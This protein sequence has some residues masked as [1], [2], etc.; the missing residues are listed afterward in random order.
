MELKKKIIR[1]VIE[2]IIVDLMIR[3]RCFTSSFI[4]R[5]VATANLKWKNHDSPLGKA[6]D[7]EDIEL[8]RKMATVMP[9]V[10]LREY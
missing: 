6:T 5:A 7:V 10:R 4:G 3:R 1:T 8:I 9:M 2:E